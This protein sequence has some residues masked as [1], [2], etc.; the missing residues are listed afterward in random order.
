MQVSSV[1][2]QEIEEGMVV[3][4]QSDRLEG[5]RRNVVEL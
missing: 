4:T 1:S 5:L 2:L 3:H